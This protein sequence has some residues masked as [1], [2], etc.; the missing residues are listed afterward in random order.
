MNYSVIASLFY[1]IALA[2]V[3]SGFYYYKK[4]DLALHAGTWVPLT[5]MALMGYQT[6]VAGILSLIKI[7]VNII[8]IGLFDLAAAAALWFFIFKMKKYQ[9]Y[10]YES[11]DFA[12]WFFILAAVFVFLKLRYGFE[13]IPTYNSVDAAVHFS[14]ARAIVNNQSVWGMYYSAFHN[15]LLIETLGP[16]VKVSNIYKIYVSGDI[17]HLILAGS[18]FWGV[19]RRYANSTLLK[20]IGIVATIMYLMGYPLNSTIFGFAY[21]GMGITVIAFIIA[22]ADIYLHE[23]ISKKWSIMLLCFGC[24]G[25]FQSYV[26]FMP[27]VFFALL[28]FVLV[29]QAVNKKLFSV[30]TILTGLGIFLPATLLGLWYT[31]GGIFGSSGSSGGGSQ[32]TVASAINIEGGIYTDLFSNFI[33]LAPIALFGLVGI[34]KEK[35]KNY[36]L[37]LVPIDI[38]FVLALLY[39]ALK[40]QVSAYYYYKNYYMLWLL[41]WILFFIGIYYLEKNARLIACFTIAIW[42]MMFGMNYK[43]IEGRISEK[44]PNL[45]PQYNTY[46]LSHIYSFNR[47]FIAITHYSPDKIDLYTYVIENILDDENGYVPLAGGV[48]DYFWMQAIT[49]TSCQDFQYWNKG[50]DEYFSSLIN[51]NIHYIM[52]FKDNDFYTTN[53]G[54]FESL[55]KVYEN[56]TGFIGIVKEQ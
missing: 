44:N 39:K 48:E 37:F 13:L 55:E 41:A 45:C 38:L 10:K 9:K 30:Q 34:F 7:K 4:S 26:L 29:Q 3:V 12:A 1:I 5:F 18:M 53:A 54:Y 49:D 35:K 47:T 14:S 16:F 31:Y 2:A 24:Y 43:G 28:A 21:L 15:G 56:N 36:M 33:F 19:I 51:D 50:Q 8:T 27:V 22:S 17:M 6:L 11:A 40:H 32:T 52:V 25:V 23:E 42:L 20:A 46:N